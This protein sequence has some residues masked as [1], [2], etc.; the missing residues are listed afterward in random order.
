MS[1]ADVVFRDMC[2]DIMENGTDTRGE[3]VR[4][5]WIE[6]DGTKTPAYTMKKFG[7]VNRY[8]LRKE[9]PATTFRK[10]AIKSC[11]DEL[12]WIWQKKSNNIKDLNSHVWDEWADKTGSI[13]AAY[14]YQQG[15]YHR[16]DDVTVKGLKKAFPNLEKGIVFDVNSTSALGD[17]V[18][19]GYDVDKNVLNQ[20]YDYV[21]K[22]IA[23]KDGRH[24]FMTQIDKAIYDL[25]NTPYSR[26][27]IVDMWNPE[28]QHKMHLTPCAYSFTF[29]VTN[30]NGKLT[31]N[32]ILNQRSND[33]L[34]AGN[35]NVCQY[36]LLLMTIAQVVGMEAGV[37]IHVIADA[38]IYDRHIPIV[39]EMIEREQYPAP[40]VWIDPEIKNFYEFSPKNLHVEDYITGPQIKNIPIAV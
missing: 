37:L 33:L 19:Y 25:I 11:Y 18:A 32:G 23:Y 6:E 13:G 9:F 38:H 3:I 21:N 7:V 15:L 20:G 26:R 29:N 2:L 39:K 34:A 35:W 22:L 4:P 12:L 8:D 1:Y 27:I 17:C 10:T 40:K 28:D 14:G 16:Y 24:F 30:E 5:M 31:L 36:S